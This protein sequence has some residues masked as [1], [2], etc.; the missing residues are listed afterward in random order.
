MNII[1]NSF[2]FSGIL[3]FLSTFIVHSN[4]MIEQNI[5]IKKW[6]SIKFMSCCLMGVILAE[7]FKIVCTGVI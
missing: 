3:I 6:Y 2:I 4:L 7:L 5:K 1:I